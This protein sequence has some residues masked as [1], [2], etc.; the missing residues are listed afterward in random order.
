MSP[1]SSVTAST[2][3]TFHISPSLSQILLAVLSSS[4]PSTTLVPSIERSTSSTYSGIYFRPQTSIDPTNEEAAKE[5]SKVST[6]TALAGAGAAVGA[7]SMGVTVVQHLRKPKT[8][9][10]NNDTDDRGRNT[11]DDDDNNRRNR[12]DNNN[13]D[14]NGGDE[15]N[16]KT[17]NESRNVNSNEDL[18]YDR[19][20]EYDEE[21][22][23]REEYDEGGEDRLAIKI[24][25]PLESTKLELSPEDFKQ[26]TEM[27]RQNKKT[28]KIL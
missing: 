2:S 7:I 13:S 10:N 24:K 27:L 19:R 14:D 11:D 4:T 16:R 3:V 21:Y 26:I 22:G 28:F 9:D 1:S 18:E 20:G 12:S 23:R 5:A 25:K 8:P 15:D 17:S 6:G